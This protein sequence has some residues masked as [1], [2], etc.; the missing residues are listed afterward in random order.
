MWARSPWK[1]AVRIVL[2]LIM[3]VL[4]L[5]VI[6]GDWGSDSMRSLDSERT[7][8]SRFAE[9]P[10]EVHK[11]SRRERPPLNKKQLA[12]INA[13]TRFYDDY[14]E[15]PNEL[16]KSA[17]RAQRKQAIQQALGG[18]RSA[19]DWAGT[20]KSM[21]TNSD[22]DAYIVVELDG[23]DF[24]VQCWNNAL[25][26][27]FDNTLIPQSSSVFGTLSELSVGDRVVFSGT[28]AS[29]EKDFIGEQ[30]ITEYGSMTDPEF[31]FRFTNV[32]RR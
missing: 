30:S 1:T 25:S 3:G 12:F 23:A 7:A 28:F 18:S 16:K 14:R 6:A 9:K 29:D 20:L 10:V 11:P 15:A 2:T 5:G 8:G 26:D 24:T 32:R 27:M 31:T 17:L 19:T 21:R 4:F 22:G 13:V